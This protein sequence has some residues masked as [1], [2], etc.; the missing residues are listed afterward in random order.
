MFIRIG[1]D[2]FN[3]D[4]IACV[5][6]IDDDDDSCVIFSAGQDAV[7]GGFLIPMPIEEVFELIQQARLVEIAQ[8]L[9]DSD[10]GSEPD[11]EPDSSS[12]PLPPLP[13]YTPSTSDD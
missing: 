4:L 9:D 13:S 1:D 10:S 12:S 8:M 7:A 11:S 2:Y 5:R 3:T 6:P